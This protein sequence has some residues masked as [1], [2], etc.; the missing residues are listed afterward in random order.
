MSWKCA[1]CGLEVADGQRRCDGCGE[2]CFR[3]I[4][5]ESLATGSGITVGIDTEITRRLLDGFAGS[6]TAFASPLQFS[7]L[8][9]I[10]HERWVIRHAAGARNP[11]FLD[12]H[13]IST[14]PVPLNGGEVISVGPDRLKLRVEIVA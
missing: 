1:Q 8:R 13:P 3:R 14:A 9:S 2:I 7:L 10:A 5:L 11:T 4:R 6:D 12:G